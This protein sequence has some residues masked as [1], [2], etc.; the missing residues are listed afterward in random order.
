MRSLLADSDPTVVLHTTRK[1]EALI[2]QAIEDA[3]NFGDD[4][5]EEDEDDFELES[6]GF[7][8][9]WDLDYRHLYGD[10]E[11]DDDNDDEEDEEDINKEVDARNLRLPLFDDKP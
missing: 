8:P 4:D 1:I 10:S 3:E 9:D 7:D 6:N 11:E 2:A 5:D